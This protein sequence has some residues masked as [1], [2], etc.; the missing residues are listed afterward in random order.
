MAEDFSEMI[1]DTKQFIRMNG[2]FV[3]RTFIVERPLAFS[4]GFN[5][6]NFI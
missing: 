4:N 6:F 2:E 3:V 5:Q 1:M